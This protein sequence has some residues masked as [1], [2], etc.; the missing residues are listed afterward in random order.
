MVD[1]REN[2]LKA[3]LQAF[4]G[5]PTPHKVLERLISDNPTPILYGLADPKSPA[6]PM[7]RA[8][9]SACF[10]RSVRPMGNKRRARQD[11]AHHLALHAFALA[12]NDSHT[13]KACAIS[14]SQIFFDHALDLARR[15]GVK[16]K[17]IENLHPHGFRKRI[18]GINLFIIVE[19]FPVRLALIRRLFLPSLQPFTKSH[20]NTRPIRFS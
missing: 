19:I 6:A 2:A 15:D 20:R 5:A 11:I 7:I 18:E 17:D 12:V 8:A 10:W 14:L 3:L 1:E 13:A 16:I 9:V 4:D